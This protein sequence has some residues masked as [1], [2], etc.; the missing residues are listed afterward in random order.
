MTFGQLMKQ[1]VF[2]INFLT[3]QLA[4]A[5]SHYCYYLIGYYIKYIPGN[6]YEAT[7]VSAIAEFVACLSSGFIIN[8]LGPQLTNM[9]SFFVSGAFGLCMVFTPP[10]QTTLILVW[11]LLTKFGVSTAAS[12][13]YVTTPYYFPKN[14]ISQVFG[15]LAAIGK[16]ISLLAP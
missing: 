3:L 11:L 12:I 8:K 9:V 2:F 6:I 10:H 5:S 1:R 7:V 15:Y 14:S 13:C 16:F 4:W